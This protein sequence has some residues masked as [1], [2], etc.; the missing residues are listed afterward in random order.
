ML[1]APGKYN[2][3][4][5][6]PKHVKL[7]CLSTKLTMYMN[8]RSSLVW[9]G[10]PSMGHVTF[11]GSRE[12]VGKCNSTSNLAQV[13]PAFRYKPPPYSPKG[14]LQRPGWNRTSR[15]SWQTCDIR[16]KSPV[17]PSSQQWLL[18][19]EPQKIRDWLPTSATK[20]QEKHLHNK[21]LT[22]ALTGD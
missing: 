9:S 17:K 7:P 10:A 18:P 1:L 6:T 5:I 19:I 2:A 21:Y 22:T 15:D 16:I 3:P 20:Q 12:P 4:T 11:Y 13:L 14:R 8:M